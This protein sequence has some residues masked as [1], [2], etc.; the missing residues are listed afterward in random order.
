VFAA[1]LGAAPFA[2]AQSESRDSDDAA[3]LAEALG[4][5]EGSRV[6][7]IGAGDGD[8]T[9]AMSRRVGEAGR[10]FATE[11][12]DNR[13]ASLKRAVERAGVGNVDVLTGDPLKTNLEAGCCDAVFMRNVYHHFDDPDAM[14]L[15]LFESLRPGGMLA[16]MDFTPPS[17]R[18]Q[19]A[20]S[21]RDTDGSHG[22]DADAV[23]E[24]LKRAGFDLVAVEK[25]ADREVLVVARKPRGLAY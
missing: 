2:V 18:A 10:V 13:V 3:R 12:G 14:N 20:P 16:V 15:S 19:V 21:A 17:G 6:A 23:A 22:V 5:R 9:I 8:L 11:L 25:G 24:E 1:S 4:I 7:E